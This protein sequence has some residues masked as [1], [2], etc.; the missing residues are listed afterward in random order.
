MLYLETKLK[1]NGNYKEF[2][3]FMVNMKYLYNGELLVKYKKSYAPVPSIRRT[4]VSNDFVDELMYIFD[5]EK[6][7]YEKLK[8]LTDKE[9]NL[10]KELVMKS[11]LYDKLK[12]NYKNSR[13]NIGDI[14][15]EYEIVKGEIEA[16][17]DNPELLTKI[18]SIVKKLY[19][20]GKISENE[21]RELTNE[22]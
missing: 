7:D 10:F 19:H 17:N 4:K 8:E 11:G 2:G 21:Y 13:E 3:K 12:Y 9:N 14:I 20:Y 5:T 6:I 1:S 15:E 22:I 18:K 16:D